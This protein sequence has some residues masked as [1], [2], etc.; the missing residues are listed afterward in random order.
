MQAIERTFLILRALRDA[1]GSAGVGEVARATSLPKSTVSRLLA[2]L[3]KEGMVDRLDVAGNYVLGSGLAAL[4]DQR[5]FVMSLRDV[6][7]PLLRQLVDVTGESAGL[8]VPDGPSALYLDHAG[9]GGSVRTRDWTGMRFPYH[10]VAGGLA[11]MMTWSDLEIDAYALRGLEAFTE[12]TITT[13]AEL[14]GRITQARRDGTV[15]TLA[16]FDN[17]I[18]GVGAPVRDR[19][20]LAVGAINV[21]G[22]TYRFPS[23]QTDDIAALV[24]QTA[25]LVEDRY[26]QD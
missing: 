5:S 11:M 19:D 2:S 23:G 17:E 20:G 15:W 3:E 4:A 18:N 7:A 24:L 14:R 26:R 6:A 1:D 22:P 8:T 16:E 10:T 21:Y 12:A 25:R 13:A 9:S